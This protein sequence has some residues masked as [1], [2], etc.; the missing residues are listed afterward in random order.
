MVEFYTVSQ[1]ELIVMND[2]LPLPGTPQ[3]V[4]NLH[5]PSNI[6]KITKESILNT[7]RFFF[8]FFFWGGGGV[9]EYPVVTGAAS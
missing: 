9:E 1:K 3:Q 4:H 6:E 5:D 8:F 7:N 2:V